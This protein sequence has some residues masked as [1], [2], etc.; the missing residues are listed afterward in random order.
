[1]MI[2]DALALALAE[3][4]D[5]CD[6]NLML[7]SEQCEILIENALDWSRGLFVEEDPGLHDLS[8]NLGE[9][10][11]AGLLPGGAG[12]F[13]RGDDMIWVSRWGRPGLQAGDWVMKGRAN[14]WNYIRSGKYQPG[15]GNQFASFSSGR[16]YLVSRG[17]VGWPRGW[18][19]WKGIFGQRQYFGARTY[20]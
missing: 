8:V 11:F 9:F 20:R 6:D 13:G 17:S 7:P 14:M 18:E 16:N 2:A 10:G 4:I 1:L 3:Y 5:T 19:R 12:L 15:W